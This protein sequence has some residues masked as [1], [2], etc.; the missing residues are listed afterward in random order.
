MS[1]SLR[2][3]LMT[4][5]FMRSLFNCSVLS[6][7][8]CHAYICAWYDLPD[9]KYWSDHVVLKCRVRACPVS[10]CA[11]CRLLDLRC[12]F[13]CC[14]VLLLWLWYSAQ[15]CY[16]DVRHSRTFTW[17]MVVEFFGIWYGLSSCL[18]SLGLR[19]L[20]INVCVLVVLLIGIVVNFFLSQVALNH[21]YWIV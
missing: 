11:V 19:H 20:I 2:C 12:Y 1:L 8:V 3:P 15:T 6:G 9:S 16:H 18:V 13:V 17:Y 21:K 5:R 14:Q 4:H 10:P 7:G